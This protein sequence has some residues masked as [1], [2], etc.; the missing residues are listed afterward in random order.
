MLV[1][2][3]NDILVEKHILKKQSARQ[4]NVKYQSV[5]SYTSKCKVHVTKSLISYP[6]IL[7]TVWN[8]TSKERSIKYTGGMHRFL[9]LHLE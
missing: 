6:L 5:N 9:P 4:G 2:F 1:I 8:F 3:T 7:W